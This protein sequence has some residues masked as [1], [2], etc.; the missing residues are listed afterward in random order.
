MI[1]EIMD[2]SARLNVGVGKETFRSLFPDA[3]ATHDFTALD[4]ILPH[5]VYGD[6]YWLCM[7][8]PSES[9]FKQLKPLLVEAH[10]LSA[11]RHPSSRASS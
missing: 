7:L 9:T 6:M 10:Q 4:H 3:S 11:K 5:P 1:A 2:A 8:S